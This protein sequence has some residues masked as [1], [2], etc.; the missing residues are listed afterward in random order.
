MSKINTIAL[1]LLLLVNII[2][3]PLTIGCAQAE[4]QKSTTY[5]NTDTVD[6]T[7]ES[8]TIEYISKFISDSTSLAARCPSF[9]VSPGI[10]GCGSV[11][12]GNV[13]AFFDRYD[14]NLIPN[15]TAGKYLGN[16]YLYNGEDA[17]ASQVINQLYGYMNSEDHIGA[18]EQEFVDGLTRYCTEKG[19]KITFTSCMNKKNFSYSSAKSNLKSNQPIILFLSSYTLC[20]IKQQTNSDLLEYNVSDV[21]HIMVAFGY[22]THTYVTA[23]GTFDYEFLKVAAGLTYMSEGLFNINYKTEIDD[24]LAVNIY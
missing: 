5:K 4:Q 1:V 24:A 21:N 22:Q 7:Y 12:A 11:A 15:H 20:T 3:A 19:K 18:T 14:E 17:G 9:C 23:T 10:G 16:L 13:L 6:S 2:C 8:E